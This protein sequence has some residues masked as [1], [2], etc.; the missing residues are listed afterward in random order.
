MVRSFH[1]SQKSK[2]VREIKRN[3]YAATL[4]LNSYFP[5][6]VQ[7]NFLHSFHPSNELLKVFYGSYCEIEVKMFQLAL[8]LVPVG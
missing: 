3:V 5:V 1:Y 7:I 2:L 6:R 4:R 8:Y